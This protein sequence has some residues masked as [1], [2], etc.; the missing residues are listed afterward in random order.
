M[1]A[2]HVE[3]QVLLVLGGEVTELASKRFPSCGMR[4]VG[5]KQEV[6]KGQQGKQTGS[7]C[8]LEKWGCRKSGTRQAGRQLL[9]PVCLTAMC[10]TRK[11]S[12]KVEYL[13]KLHL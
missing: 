5:I 7:D 2:V 6:P 8:L 10:E 4:E 1:A 13:Q 9:S 3:A 12:R 11:S